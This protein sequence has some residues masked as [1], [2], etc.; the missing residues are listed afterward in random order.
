MRPRR[1]CWRRRLSATEPRIAY[2]QTRSAE[3]DIRLQM[4]KL[5]KVYAG[6]TGRTVR[7]IIAAG[8]ADPAASRALVE[9]YI[10]PRRQAACIAI[11]RGIASGEF[12]PELDVE[13]VIDALYG[14]IFYR[15]LVGHAPLD[16]RWIGQLT[17]VVFGRCR[18]A[19]GPG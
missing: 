4:R 5:A 9:G 2:P 19:A 13:A 17:A 10:R 8:E 6:K 15:L 1:R 7:G 18:R 11:E 12:R 3:A 16:P 14:P